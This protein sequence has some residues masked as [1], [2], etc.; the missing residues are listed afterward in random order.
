MTFL[1][2]KADGIRTVS[3]QSLPLARPQSWRSEFPSIYCK[4]ASLAEKRQA[5]LQ[6]WLDS[7]LLTRYM[8][9]PFKDPKSSQH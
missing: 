2:Q 8:E 3:S 6:E 4:T 9:Q 1:S 7:A 5:M